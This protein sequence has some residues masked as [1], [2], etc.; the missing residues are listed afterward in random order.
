MIKTKIPT[1]NTYDLKEAENSVKEKLRM[2]DFKEAYN[3][4][5]NLTMK[6]I[7]YFRNL[8]NLF[9]LEFF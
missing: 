4:N 5:G 7:Y 6:Y 8:Q 2:V 9:D 1:L 3:L